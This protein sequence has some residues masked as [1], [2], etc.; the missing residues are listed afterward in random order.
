MCHTLL[1][2]FSRFKKNFVGRSYLSHHTSPS[3]L[4]INVLSFLLNCIVVFNTIDIWARGYGIF[5]L[6]KFVFYII[7]SFTFNFAFLIPKEINS[8]LIRHLTKS[9]VSFLLSRFFKSNFAFLIVSFISDMYFVSCRKLMLSFQ[10][11]LPL[12]CSFK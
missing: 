5:K 6:E 4:V 7:Q 2:D 3:S 10:I 12:F 9:Q 1:F 11:P 8:V